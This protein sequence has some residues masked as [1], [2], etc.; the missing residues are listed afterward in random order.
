[1][2]NTLKG[3]GNGMRKVIHGINTPLVTR[4]LMR[5]VLDAIQGGVSHINIGRGHVNLGAQHVCPF[6]K[7]AV[8]HTGKQL[9][10]LFYRAV[11]IRTVFAGFGQG[12]TVFSHFFGR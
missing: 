1:M 11:A 3:I 12:T 5:L 4:F 10:V 6:G 8:A 7:V 9:Q 2:R